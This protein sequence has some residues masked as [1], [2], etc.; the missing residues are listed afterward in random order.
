MN[1]KF[2]K[3]K[4]IAAGEATAPSFPSIWTHE[5]DKPLIGT[6]KEFSQ[7]EHDRYG[8]QETVIVELESGERVSAIL[9]S[10][11]STGMHIQH[12]E[13]NDS[14]LIQLLGKERNSHGTTFNKFSLVVEKT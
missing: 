7:F 4:A 12:A 6:I 9:N 2:A 13:V 1:D 11:L 10:Y 5:I 8:T 3:L 14:V